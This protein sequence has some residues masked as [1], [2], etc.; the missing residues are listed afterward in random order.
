[1]KLLLASLLLAP[2]LVFAQPPQ[3]Y[4]I[5]VLDENK[6]VIDTTTFTYPMLIEREKIQH[7]NQYVNLC[8][9]NKDTVEN[10]YKQIPSIYSLDTREKYDND[11]VLKLQVSIP[12]FKSINLGDCDIQQPVMQSFTLSTNLPF[13]LYEQKFKVLDSQG[14]ATDKEYTIN[15]QSQK[16]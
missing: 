14:K 5:Q 6:H 3:E 1:M 16:K 12:V 15:L 2:T 4:K 8:L 11:S 7:D 9:K 13:I 10:N